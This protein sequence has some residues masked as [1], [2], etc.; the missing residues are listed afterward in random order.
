MLFK[1]NAKGENQFEQSI[2][3]PLNEVKDIDGKEV[4]QLSA[5]YALATTYLYRHKDYHRAIK[6]YHKVLE[7]NP[8]P[9]IAKIAY[10][11]LGFC[12]NQPGIK[13][14]AHSIEINEQAVKLFP[15]DEKLW[16]NLGTAYLGKGNLEKATQ[17][18]N[19][20]FKLSPDSLSAGIVYANLGSIYYHTGKIEKARFHFEK[21]KEIFQK[22]NE[23]DYLNYINS[24][25]NKIPAS[26]KQN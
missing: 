4:D 1:G 11:N 10:E 3:Y 13:D 14:F 2:I 15:Q 6:C 18:Y 17:C 24:F 9:E 19:K 20:I 5:N 16:F 8:P 26:S 7:L 23:Q 25:L 22:N 12:Y 21:A